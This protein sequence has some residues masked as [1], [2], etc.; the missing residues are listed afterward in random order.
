MTAPTLGP[1]D[2]VISPA[3]N[4]SW[5]GALPEP[6]PDGRDGPF[7]TPLA[8]RNAI[9]A[10]RRRGVGGPITVWLRGGDYPMAAP[11]RLE[12]VDGGPVTWRAWPGERPVLSGGRRVS[13]WTVGEDAGRPCWT[14]DLGPQSTGD[15]APRSLWVDGRRA[16]R[17]R[18]PR[19]DV[20]PG[21]LRLA[22]AEAIDLE[23]RT[24][25]Q[26]A[27][28]FAG[29]DRFWVRP[30]DLPEIAHPDEVDVV[31][32]HYWV[33]Q[34]LPIASLDPSTGEVR[35]RRRSSMRLVD[36]FSGEQARYYLDNVREA[37]EPGEWHVAR[38]TGRLTYLPLPGQD[39]ET[40]E[41]VV[42][43]LRQLLVVEGDPDGATVDWLRFEGITFAHTDWEVVADP[44][45]RWPSHGFEP[46]VAYAATG[47]AAVDLPGVVDVRG[48]RFLQLDR[49]EV[50]GAGWYAVNIGSGCRSVSLT[51]SLF[52]DLGAGGVKVDGGAA[53]ERASLRTYGVTIEDCA[54]RTAGLVFHA[55]VGI[56]GVHAG[57]LRIRHCE[58]TDLDY[59]GVSLGWEWGYAESASRDNLVE[60][61][62]ISRIGRGR[63]SDLGGIY[64][65]GVQPGTV[66]RGNVISDVMSATYGAGGIYLDEG[67]SHIVVEGNCV[68]DVETAPLQVHFGRENV[69]RENLLVGGDKGSVVF[70][71]A[72]D[73]VAFTLDRNVLVTSAGEWFA[74]GVGYAAADPARWP[75]RS[76]LNVLWGDPVPALPQ[77]WLDAGRDR[78][79]AVCDPQLVDPKRPDSGFAPGSPVPSLGGAWDWSSVGPRV[80]PGASDLQP[81]A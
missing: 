64:T 21:H 68:Y 4:D 78:H 29:T 42:P 49:C 50:R 57:G 3:G 16:P 2:L 5:T 8:A 69:V 65:L 47:Q 9:R 13:G 14:L 26:E 27:A 1:D 56:I 28:L 62:R 23:G 53:H 31:V 74:S 80:E 54:V 39:P 52:A 30:Q 70:H 17:G 77:P 34:R 61:C 41:V 7:A 15:A 40:T 73:H 25:P 55:A 46:G 12:P 71:K 58:V 44:H 11:L 36:D 59:S 18:F 79:A 35:S 10:Q 72:E 51:R 37:L 81:S 20:G 63:L 24:G 67:S 75:V 38:D 43:R 45:R 48:A 19:A 66:L 33:E 22:R 60:S 76:D 32:T 6:A